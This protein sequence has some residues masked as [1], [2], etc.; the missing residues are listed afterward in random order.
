MYISFRY[1][2]ENKRTKHIKSLFVCVPLSHFTSPHTAGRLFCFSFSRPPD[3]PALNSVYLHI[4]ALR[5]SSHKQR[6]LVNR[7]T[8]LSVRSWR[9][10]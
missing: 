3:P 7:I 5:I 2:Y 1:W 8:D 4:P 9:D 6:E 10:C